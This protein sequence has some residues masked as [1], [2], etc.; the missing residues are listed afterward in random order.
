MRDL[1]KSLRKK[2]ILEMD[3]ELAALAWSSFSIDAGI[4]TAPLMGGFRQW[5]SAR[6]ILAAE[7]VNIHSGSAG[8]WTN[9]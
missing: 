5:K 8:R 6:S 1:D 4:R 3:T 2:L 9:V 7:E